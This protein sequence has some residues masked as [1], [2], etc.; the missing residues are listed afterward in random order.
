MSYRRA[1]TNPISIAEARA[2]RQLVLQTE[3]RRAAMGEVRERIAPGGALDVEGVR[4]IVEVRELADG[5]IRA[6]AACGAFRV[7]SIARWSSVEQVARE[8]GPDLLEHI[9][10]VHYQIVE[11]AAAIAHARASAADELWP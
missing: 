9:D 3:G 8:L 10:A 5:T 11:A 4:W 7:Y 6:D 1:L 2:A